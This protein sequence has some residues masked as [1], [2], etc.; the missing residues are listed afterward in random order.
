MRVLQG[1]H[2]GRDSTGSADEDGARAMSGAG[3][4]GRSLRRWRRGAL[5]AGGVAIGLA[6]P[7]IAGA[8]TSPYPDVPTDHPFVADIAWAKNIGLVSGYSDGNYRPGNPVTRGSMTGFL[9][10]LYNIQEM[11]GGA[12]TMWCEVRFMVDPPGATGWMPMGPTA[13]DTAFDDA[14]TA[15]TY[16]SHAAQGFL[17]DYGPG[18]YLVKVQYRTQDG[19]DSFWLDDWMLRVDTDL[20]SY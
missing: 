16:E 14:E 13:G 17:S 2:D 11:S 10:R 19:A 4:A 3:T 7:Q 8:V 15:I 20:M 12:S 1:W 9:R 5:L 18:V 6:V